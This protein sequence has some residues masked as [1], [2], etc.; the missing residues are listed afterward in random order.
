MK[1][2]KEHFDGLRQVIAQFTSSRPVSDIYN[3]YMA[4]GKSDVRFVWDMYWAATSGL[5]RYR[6]ALAEWYKD[7]HVETALKRILLPAN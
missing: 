1:M 4:A 3:E 7:T 6:S 5:H 2:S